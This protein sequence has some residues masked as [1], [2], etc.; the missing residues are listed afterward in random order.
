MKGCRS[1]RSDEKLIYECMRVVRGGDGVRKGKG[2]VIFTDGTMGG[3][4]RGTE[5]RGCREKGS[6]DEGVTVRR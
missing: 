4:H 6:G 3:G 2:G 1:S 5:V